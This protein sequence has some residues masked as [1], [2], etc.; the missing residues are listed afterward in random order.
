MPSLRSL[1]F[2]RSH[3]QIQTVFGQ[4]NLAIVLTCVKVLYIE[5]ISLKLGS[6]GNIDRKIL[7]R[8]MWGKALLVRRQILV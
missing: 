8:T 1:E 7:T 2:F 4:V 6:S 3:D 5:S